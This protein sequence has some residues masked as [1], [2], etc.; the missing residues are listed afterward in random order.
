MPIKIETVSGVKMGTADQDYFLDDEGKLTTD[1]EK[2]ATLL[3]RKGQDVPKEMAEKY[4]SDGDNAE[5]ASADEGEKASSPKSNKAA[6]P[7]GN[8][9]AK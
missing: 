8:K 4:F 7:K 6:S 5:A 9:G 2:A 1:Q 3:I